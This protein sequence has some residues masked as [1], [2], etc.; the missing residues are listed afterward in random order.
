MSYREYLEMAFFALGAVAFAVY[1]FSWV[2][3]VIK[4]P[5]DF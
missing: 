4:R 3:N 1:L 2:R 5:E